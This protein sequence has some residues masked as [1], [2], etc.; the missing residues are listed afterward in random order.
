MV[1]AMS[2]AHVRVTVVSDYLCPWCYVGMAR[3]ERLEREFDVDLTWHPFEL[4]PEIPA[5]GIARGERPPSP[6]RAA[7]YEQL[8]ALAEDAGLPFARTRRVPNTHRALE[9]AE[10]AREHGAF[11][12]Y[13]RSLF[14]AFFGQGRDIGDLAVLADV[15][16]SCGLDGGALRSALQAG[17]FTKVV[18]ERTA[19]ARGWGVTGTPT[20]I[21]EAGDRRFPVVGAQDYAVFAHIAR[22]FGAAERA[23]ASA[24]DTSSPVV[25]LRA[26]SLEL[27]E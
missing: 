26:S 16:A 4:H 21:F 7:M 12:P 6:Q 1:A 23:P 14:D 13:H 19:E 10:F 25:P 22:R 24:S 15:A 20:V 5:E 2:D 8:R 3:V 9:A 17:R 18:D 27:R 11:L